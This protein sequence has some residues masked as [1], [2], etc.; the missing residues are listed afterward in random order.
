MS[1]CSAELRQAAETLNMTDLKAL[2]RTQANAAK[3]PSWAYVL[4]AVLTNSPNSIPPE[5]IFSILNDSFDDDQ[6][7]SHADLIEYSL[8]SQYNCRGRGQAT[9]ADP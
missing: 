8:Q 2:L 7:S 9:V 5:R 1:T 3:I 4:R 6:T